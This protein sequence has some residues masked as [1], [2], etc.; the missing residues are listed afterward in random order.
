MT[1]YDF[2]M[3]FIIWSYV[4]GLVLFACLF[5]I[6]DDTDYLVMSPI[7][8]VYYIKKLIKVLRK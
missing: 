3:C 1:F 7:W 5:L 4:V 8:P 6:Y 2:I